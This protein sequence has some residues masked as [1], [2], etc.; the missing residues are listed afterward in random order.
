MAAN[1]PLVRFKALIF[2]WFYYS[3]YGRFKVVNV[4]NIPC[5]TISIVLPVVCSIVVSVIVNV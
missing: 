3:P 1:I 4:S 2:T 5:T